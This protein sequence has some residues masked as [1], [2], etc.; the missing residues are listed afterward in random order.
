VPEIASASSSDDGGVSRV[1]KSNIP[2]SMPSPPSLRGLEGRHRRTR[3]V[4]KRGRQAY[5]PFIETCIAAFGPD[6]GMFREQF[7]A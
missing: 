5:K 2:N 1:W 6:R 7:P 3:Q 4:P